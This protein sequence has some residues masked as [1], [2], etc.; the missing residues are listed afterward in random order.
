MGNNTSPSLPAPGLL[1]PHLHSPSGLFALLGVHVL[2]PRP[3]GLL[4]WGIPGNDT[5]KFR[6]KT[7]RQ[8]L[9]LNLSCLA[10]LRPFLN[11]CLLSHP[12][13]SFFLLLKKV[14]LH[15][16]LTWQLL[17]QREGSALP[18]RHT[19]WAKTRFF[20]YYFLSIRDEFSSHR[21]RGEVKCVST[22]S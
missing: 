21:A 16:G 19:L 5:F 10:V 9:C 20:F 8:P 6:Q 11:C 3:S 4:C 15:P 18:S 2:L 12:S 17:H 14:P 7:E 22:L 13:G 1:P